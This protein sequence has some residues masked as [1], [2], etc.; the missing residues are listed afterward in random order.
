MLYN[1]VMDNRLQCVYVSMSWPDT[2]F[3]WAGGLINHLNSA[4]MAG[5]L[6][7]VCIL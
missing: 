2:M 6:I 1:L 3:Y 5:G 7:E 4:T